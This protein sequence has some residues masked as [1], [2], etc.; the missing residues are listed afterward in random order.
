MECKR[1]ILP[2]MGSTFVPGGALKVVSSIKMED[3]EL[4]EI[5]EAEVFYFSAQTEKCVKIVKKYLRSE[6][7]MLR[8]SADM[9]YTFANMTLGDI[10][11]VQIA[12]E[13]VNNCMKNALHDHLNPEI[14][15]ACLFAVYAISILIHIPPENDFPLLQDYLRYLPKGQRL[16]ALHMMAHGAYLEKEYAKG[17]GIAQTA[18]VMPDQIYPIPFI[19]LN[20][21]AAVCQINQKNSDGAQKSVMKAWE[22]AS[23]DKFVEPFIEYH[24]LLQGV[25]E[26]WVKNEVPKAY[27]RL[28]KDVNSFGSGWRKIHNPEMQKTVTDVLTP[29]EF[30]IAMLACRDWTNKEIA[31]HMCLSVNTIKHYVSI[32]LGKLGIAKRDEIKDYVNQ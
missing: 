30:S 14:Q 5:A 7:I 12:R 11:A 32:I 9:L 19:Y 24:D 3:K 25:L 15:A 20:C 10:K 8:M 23:K 27:K 26:V 22:I 16:F 21:L 29:M 28:M 13:D 2:L 6:D 17:Q 1:T 31:E 18:L 4:A